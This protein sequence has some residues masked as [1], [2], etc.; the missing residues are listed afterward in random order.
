MQTCCSLRSRPWNTRPESAC[1]ARTS[2]DPVRAFLLPRR[3]P[4]KYQPVSLTTPSEA[5]VLVMATGLALMI[6]FPLLALWLP[7]RLGYL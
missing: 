2:E 3:V 7:G 1:R 4:D 5:V 6:V